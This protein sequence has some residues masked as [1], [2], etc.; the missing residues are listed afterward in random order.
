VK[1]GGQ[2]YV[3]SFT[4]TPT[5]STTRTLLT[6]ADPASHTWA[7]YNPA[8]HLD[9]DP[10]GASFSVIEFS[11]LEAVGFY[12]GMDRSSEAAIGIRNSG[13]TVEATIVPKL[14][15]TLPPVPESITYPASSA[16]G[17]YAVSWAG[18]AETT[19]YHLERSNDN[20][21]T[22]TQ[23][24]AGNATSLAECLDDGSYFYRVRAMSENGHSGWRA[25]HGACVVSLSA[26]EAWRRTAFAEDPEDESLA[27]PLADPNDDGIVNL[28][29]FALR[30]DPHVED[31]HVILPRLEADPGFGLEYV[32]RV[33]GEGAL[34]G[35]GGYAVDDITYL[36]ERSLTQDEIQWH[37]LALTPENASW[38]DAPEGWMIRVRLDPEKEGMAFF[39]LRVQAQ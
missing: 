20:G 1:T 38:V 34:D 27:G 33:R 22:W 23:I 15:L 11:G 28:L 26:Q 4:T 18:S 37:P 39:R 17:R 24:L 30:G 36:V 29:K 19:G 10:E 35:A 7:P 12:Y 5:T 14:S 25:G 16:T 21:I 8:A 3:S 32:F 13:L 9:F 2:Y 31:G 6:L